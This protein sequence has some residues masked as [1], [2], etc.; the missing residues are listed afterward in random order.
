M[1]AIAAAA[2]G[3]RPSTRHAIRTQFF[4]AGFMFATWGVHIPT[5][6]GIYGITEGDLGLALLAA[7]IGSLLGL[8]QA[9]RVI[10]RFGPRRLVLVCGVLSTVALASLL[11]LPSFIALIAALFGFGIVGGVFDVAIN[12]EASHIEGLE[13]RPL[14]SGFHGMFSLGGMAGAGVGAW[15]LNAGV[16]PVAHIVG[17]SLALALTIAGAST[18]ML[19]TPPSAGA[20]SSFQ[21]PRGVLLLLGAMAGL[22][23]IAEGAMYDWSVL[24][25]NTALGASQG[26]AALAYASFSAAMAATRFGGDA[27]RRRFPPATLLR[28]SGLL[29][30]AAMA[31]VL[32]AGHWAIAL[33]G[34]A[35]VGVGF[36]NIVPVLFSAA[37]SMPGHNP[38]HAIAAVSSIG[39]MGFMCGPPLIGFVAQHT[40]LSTALWLVVGF[41]C[42]LAATSA[43]VP[44]GLQKST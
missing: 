5:V 36:A 17:A 2:P 30:A 26:V 8:S 15:M 24:Y 7:G 31:V 37:G 42:V 40:S 44:G 10:G 20:H 6:K 32:L 35:L 33:V 1:T 41:A 3:I 43:K 25:L 16:A 29:A 21:W 39:Y 28:A 9:G 12:A 14:M 27:L 18:C 38:A 11:S 22:G 19:K 23:L 34:F 4:C 13:G